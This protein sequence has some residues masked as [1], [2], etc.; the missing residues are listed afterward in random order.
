[1]LTVVVVDDEHLVRS[2]FAALLASDPGLRVVGEAGDGRSAVQVIRRERPDVVLLDIRMPGRDGIWAARQVSSDPTLSGTRIIVLTTFDADELVVAAL[3]AGAAGFLLK[4]C[5]PTDL[6][7]AVHR[8]AAGEAVL[9]PSL[10]GRLIESYV[11]RPEAPSQPR[12]LDALTAREIE[13]L[14]EVARG[15]SNG[16]IGARLHMSPATA[17][18]HVGRLLHKIGAR[19]RT[20][21]VIA[22]Y[23]AGLV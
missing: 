8:A 20:Q 22:A 11:Q 21:L 14:L 7:R 9:A 13:V 5:P 6:L 1:M 19:D 10:L 2:G 16:E 3:R 18:T 4:D 15:L 17:K 23:E 12:W